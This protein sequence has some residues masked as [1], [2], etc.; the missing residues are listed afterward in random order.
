MEKDLLMEQLAILD[1]QQKSRE[2]FL[3]A[4]EVIDGL[5]SRNIDLLISAFF[6]LR[7][8]KLDG[9]LPPKEL[10]RR[11][12]IL[13]K[14]SDEANIA[15]MHEV[16]EYFNPHELGSY[17]EKENYQLVKQYTYPFEVEKINVG[18]GRAIC[19]G[20]DWFSL[21]S[22]WTG[23]TKVG[24]YSNK[25]DPANRTQASFYDND[26]ILVT[27]QDQIHIASA[28]NDNSDYL[29]TQKIGSTSK[30]ILAGRAFMDG[31]IVLALENG[32]VAELKRVKGKFPLTH[33]EKKSIS[34]SNYEN[35]FIMNDGRVLFIGSEDS[36]GASEVKIHDWSDGKFRDFTSY[37]NPI[38]YIANSYR[39]YIHANK[40]II[41]FSNKD[42]WR[43]ERLVTPPL[44]NAL[45]QP[46]SDTRFLVG[47]KDG[48]LMVYDFFFDEEEELV[49]ELN[50][51]TSSATDIQ[52]TKDGRIYIAQGNQLNVFDG[53]E[54]KRQDDN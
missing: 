33:H 21:T 17:K 20:M 6:I 39:N 9:L 29:Y 11:Q 47:S 3:K 16:V 25:Y 38:K 28:S 8:A 22:L 53:D 37:L 13:G 4:Q 52:M 1:N 18:L 36:G 48:E 12:S 31:S 49:R 10:A 43:G 46:I 19:Y 44:S 27:Y 15:L 51:P 26:Q 45:V 30:P 2:Y 54:V 34:K 32:D 41:D 14:I 40:D 24:R 35:S 7:Q 23:K 5:E 50:I 42:K